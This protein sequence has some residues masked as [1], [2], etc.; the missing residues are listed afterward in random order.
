MPQCFLSPVR[1][2][3]KVR[4]LRHDTVYLG[5]TQRQP[6]AG[7]LHENQGRY[8]LL[9]CT[10]T[11]RT[12]RVRLYMETPHSVFLM[13]HFY[14]FCTYSTRVNQPLIAHFLPHSITL[15]NH[16]DPLKEHW[17]SV[18]NVPALK[19]NT[20]LYFKNKE[21]LSNLSLSRKRAL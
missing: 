13:G 18:L 16:S 11:E 1:T 7:S 12:C 3:S 8:L 10:W 6:V 17:M 14:R 15:S 5:D 20:K 2:H 4:P 21:P 19:K 9:N